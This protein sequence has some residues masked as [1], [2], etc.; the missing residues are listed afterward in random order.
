M[1]RNHPCFAQSQTIHV[2]SFATTRPLLAFFSS[3]LPLTLGEVA[4][5]RLTER[6]VKH[7]FLALKPLALFARTVRFLTEQCVA[8]IRVLLSHR[9][10]MYAPSQQHVPC[11]HF[12]RQI[13]NVKHTF[14]ALKPLAL[15]ARTVGDDIPGV[16]HSNNLH[17]R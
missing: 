2:C 15:S 13:T 17:T 1:R 3:N 14:L 11:L 12:S 9:Q 10:Y 7:T 6:A 5:V 16:P 8:I 4:V